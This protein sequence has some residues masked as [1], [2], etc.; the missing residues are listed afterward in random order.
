VARNHH[1]FDQPYVALFMAMSH[2]LSLG[3]VTSSA[4]VS[5]VLANPRINSVWLSF[6]YK[7]VYV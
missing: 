6:Y 2:V 1:L 5:V 7:Y 3:I 4:I